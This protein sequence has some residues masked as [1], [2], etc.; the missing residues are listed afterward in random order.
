MKKLMILLCAS[1]AGVAMAVE[2]FV[3]AGTHKLRDGAAVAER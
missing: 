3:V 1:A 2:A